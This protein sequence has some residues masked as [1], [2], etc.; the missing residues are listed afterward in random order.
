MI[1]QI[2]VV[3]SNFSFDSRNTL[4]KLR[5]RVAAPSVRKNKDTLTEVEKVQA[6][7]DLK[8]EDIQGRWGVDSVKQRLANN[9]VFLAR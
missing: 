6:V 9:Y 8:Q 3:K 7:V 1:T 2:S 5:K 4:F